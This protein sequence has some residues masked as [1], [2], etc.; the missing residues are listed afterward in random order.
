MIYD[1]SSRNNPC[2]FLVKRISYFV[3]NNQHTHSVLRVRLYE[4][5]ATH[6]SSGSAIAAEVFMNN[7]VR[8]RDA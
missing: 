7:G 5:R 4:R 1:G 8:R 6:K 3:C 2:A